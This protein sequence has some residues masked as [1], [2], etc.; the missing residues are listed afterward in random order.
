[1]YVSRPPCV[2]AWTCRL[3]VW[4]RGHGCREQR[5][6]TSDVPPPLGLVARRG[7]GLPEASCS[8]T[9]DVELCPEPSPAGVVEL[10]VEPL[11]KGQGRRSAVKSRARPVARRAEAM[12]LTR[13]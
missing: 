12:R 6:Y 7:A 4:G 1:M 13:R 9:A 11:L 8:V 2:P 5:R 10:S 3:S